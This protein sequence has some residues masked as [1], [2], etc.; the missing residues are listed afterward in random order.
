MKS[1]LGAQRDF[2]GGQVNKAARRRDDGD[3]VRTGALTMRNW[4]IEA[5]GQLVPRPGRRPIFGGAA[6]RTDYVRMGVGSEFFLSFSAGAITITDTLG[7]VVATN[8]SGAYLWTAQ[9]IS[10]IQWCQAEQQIVVCYPTMQP[11]LLTWNPNT[12]AWSFSA[13]AFK[14]NG[15]QTFAPF[16]NFRKDGSTMAYSAT[17][18]SVGLTCSVPFFTNSMIGNTL[19]IG[20]QQ[21]VITVVFSATQAAATVNY[22]LPAAITVSVYD[23][24]P[25]QVGQIVSARV[26]NIKFEV[27]AVGFGGVTGVLISSVPFNSTWQQSPGGVKD[28]LVS[29]YGSSDFSAAPIQAL[30]PQPTTQW[31][32]QFMSSVRGW[33]ASCFFDRGRLGFC[34]FPQKPEAILWSAIAAYTTFWIDSAAAATNPEAGAAA[35]SAILEGIPGQ[36]GQSTPRVRHVVGWGDEFAFTDRG[37]FQIP[38]SSSGNPLKPGSVEFRPISNDGVAPIRPVQSQDVIVYMNAGLTRCCVIRATGAYTRPYITQDMS[39]NHTDLFVSPITLSIATGDGQYPV[40]YVYILN[41]DGSIVTGKFTSE[42]TFVG[43]APWSSAGK[44]SWLSSAGPNVYF[45]TTYGSNALLE[46]EDAAQ[47]LDMAVPINNVPSS[48]VKSGFGPLWFYAGGTITLI[49]GNRDMGERQ[50]DGAGRIVA[51]QGEDLSSATLTAGLFS[52]PVFEP[53]IPGAQPGDDLA[54]RMRKRKIKRAMVNVE[55]SSGF[56]LGNKQFPVD[57]FTADA[58]QQPILKDGAFSTRPVGRSY[59]PTITLTKERPGPLRL[60]EFS[61]ETTI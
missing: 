46:I 13:F 12:R 20:G 26:Q 11:Q 6:A 55:I 18:G 60:C 59:D 44:V 7:N 9:T 22:L 45:N 28:T 58:T 43:W 36:P 19:S 61:V 33:P 49:D 2:S 17:S 47:W 29:P 16:F 56:T 54:Q 8:A 23:T 25:F 35:D 41:S 40:R 24:T 3:A 34:D 53:F 48:L 14:G 42:R 57:N 4:R 1:N 31:Q 38:I 10:Q 39:D 15:A 32:E 30:L 5:T 52:Q 50:V 37:I 27:T 51:I 21:C